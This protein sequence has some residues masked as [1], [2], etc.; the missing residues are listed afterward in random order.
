MSNKKALPKKKAKRSESKELES[1]R[2]YNEAIS[3]M[4]AVLNEIR[5]TV[6]VLV[7]ARQVVEDTSVKLFI[8]SEIHQYLSMLSAFRKRY[9]S[10]SGTPIP[11]ED[12]S[13]KQFARH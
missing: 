13:G 11:V 9:F 4:A 6:D 5:G 12:R 2:E 7:K 1:I 8:D 10:D 3:S